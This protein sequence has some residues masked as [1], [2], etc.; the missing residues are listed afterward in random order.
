MRISCE[1]YCDFLK[2]HG[3]LGSV[4]INTFIKQWK[5]KLLMVQISREV[6]KVSHACYHTNF[7]KP[8]EVMQNYEH[9]D[10][11]TASVSHGRPND[12]V[13]MILYG[14]V[15]CLCFPR[16][17]ANHLKLTWQCPNRWGLWKQDQS[18]FSICVCLLLFVYA[19]SKNRVFRR[20]NHQSIG[21]LLPTE[22][23]G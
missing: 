11:W 15:S 16:T 4:T 17:Y 1:E 23:S 13:E 21:V 2:M 3:S 14:I 20:L 12:C 22:V 10:I 9:V 5:M 6:G 7:E 19:D 18:P 8:C